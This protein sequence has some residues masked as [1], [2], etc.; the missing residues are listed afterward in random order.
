MST[1]LLYWE[2]N[3]SCVWPVL[4]REIGYLAQPAGNSPN[5]AQDVLAFFDT[6]AYCW[7][8]AISSFTSTPRFSSANLLSKSAIIHVRGYSSLGVGFH[9]CCCLTQ[10]V[11]C[12]PI[13]FQQWQKQLR[14]EA[15]IVSG[16]LSNFVSKAC[17]K[18]CLITQLVN[19]DVKW[20]LCLYWRE[21][22]AHVQGGAK[23]EM[24]TGEWQKSCL[25]SGLL[26]HNKSLHT[27]INAAGLW[28]QTIFLCKF[29][30]L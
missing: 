24:N 11:S 25:W 9:I 18:L 2:S 21:E 17:W 28:Q 14:A 22:V 8:I 29:S 6:K 4:S 26:L 19:E 3:S 10:W 27:F 1:P 20:D 13:Y 16:T 30:F 7:L 12:W 5:A 23:H 15:T